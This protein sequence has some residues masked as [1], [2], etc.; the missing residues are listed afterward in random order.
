M[1]LRSA[2]AEDVEFEIGGIVSPTQLKQG[3]GLGRRSLEIAGER[4][5]FRVDPSEVRIRPIVFDAI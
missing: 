4:E 5:D 1:S 3:V 2:L